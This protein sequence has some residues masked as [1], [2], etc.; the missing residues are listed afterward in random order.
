MPLFF[1]HLYDDIV[2]LDEEVQEMEDADAS[3][4]TC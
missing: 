1:F 2:S 4:S 3:M